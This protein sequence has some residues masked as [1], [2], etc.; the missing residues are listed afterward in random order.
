MWV[1]HINIT[2]LDS[3]AAGLR[4]TGFF[5]EEE[6]ETIVKASGEKEWKDLLV[7]KTKEVLD[8]GAFG[9]PWFWVKNDAGRE[10]PFFGSDR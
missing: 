10:E 8:Q 1:D 3:L 4:D 7:A 2:I 6:I 5:S 9:A